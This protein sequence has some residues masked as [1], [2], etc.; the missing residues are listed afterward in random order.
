MKIS[1]SVTE[2]KNVFKEIQRQPD[3]IFEMM[4]LEMNKGVGEYLSELMRT[5]LSHFLGREPYERKE[6]ETNHRN[7]SYG[8]QFTMKRLGEVAIEVPRDRNG[9][10]RSEVLPRSKRYEDEL[11]KDVCLMYLTGISTR[12]LSMLSKQLLGRKIS[13]GEVSRANRELVE[14]VER[15][16]TRDLSQEKIKYMLVDG[17]NFSMRVGKSV[18]TV[19]VLVAVGVKEDGTRLVLGLQAGDKESAACW[20]EFFKDLKSRGLSSE[21]VVLGVM[22]GLAGLEMVFKEEFPEAEVQRCQVHVARNVLAKVPKKLKQ[23][24]ADEIRSIFYASSKE[25]AKEFFVQFK[26]HW[27]KEVPSAVKCLE[28]SLESCLTFFKFPPEEWQALRTT[29]IIERLN[30]EFKRRTKSM[31]IVAGENACYRLLAFISLKM[32]VHWKRNP[33]GKVAYNLPIFQRVPLLDFTQNA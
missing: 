29:N 1:L 23:G 22:D 13:A 16:R 15:W 21:T 4:R 17:V 14:A 6:G 10:F 25:K 32:E 28:N 2:L 19:P 5:E 11:R 24:V 26:E 20:R 8:R 18:E 12:T 3:R 31:E 27:E 33:I 7:G 9:K 30:K